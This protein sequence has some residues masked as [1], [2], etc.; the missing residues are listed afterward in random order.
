MSINVSVSFVFSRYMDRYR[1]Q[2]QI[3]K[4]VLLKKLKNV[5]PFKKPDPPL[6]YPNAQFLDPNLPSWLKTEIRKQRLRVGRY[7]DL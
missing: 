1:D 3:A 6:K 5:H 2:K 7:K 4:E